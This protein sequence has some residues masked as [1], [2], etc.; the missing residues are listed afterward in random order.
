MA[1]RLLI[2][3]SL[4][5]VFLFALHLAESRPVLESDMFMMSERSS[6]LNNSTTGIDCGGEC[7]RRC[8]LSSRPNLCQRACGTCCA[9]CSCVPPGTSGN[10]ESCPCYANMT[11]RGGKRKCP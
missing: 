1:P 5:L 11:T 3:A 4:L 10:Y 2:L 6:L 9:R 8:K 7:A